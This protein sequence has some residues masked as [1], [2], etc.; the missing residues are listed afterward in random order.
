MNQASTQPEAG[1]LAE[2]ASDEEL[3]LRFRDRH[4]QAAFDALV[5]R[6]ERELYSY[7]KR[8]T[9]DEALAEDIFQATFLKLYEKSQLFEPGRRVRPWLYSIATH[10]AI[11]A[12]RSAGRREAMSLDAEHGGPERDTPGLLALLTDRAP[13]PLDRLEAEERKQ[14][15][16]DAVDRLPEGLRRVLILAYFQGLKYREV[17]DV[18]GIPLGTVKSRLHAALEMLTAA[19][20]A[21]SPPT[22]E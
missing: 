14:W 20:K 1:T 2:S 6:Y 21:A 9:R 5:H 18:L 8:Y 3:L 10:L 13:S 16:H 7:L 17:A 22:P 15:I 12:Q 19:W 4:D 11:D